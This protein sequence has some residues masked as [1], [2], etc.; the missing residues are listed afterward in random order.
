[1]NTTLI[2]NWC[3]SHFMVEKYTQKQA[4]DIIHVFI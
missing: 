2:V 3:Y 4:T 1:M